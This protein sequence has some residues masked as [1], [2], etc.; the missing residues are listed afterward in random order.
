MNPF[1]NTVNVVLKGSNESVFSFRPAMGP[2]R[3]Q[4]FLKIIQGFASEN[5]PT[6][7]SQ[8]VNNDDEGILKLSQMQSEEEED[9]SV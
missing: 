7:Y 9:L 4:T 6:E 3:L 8:V 5:Q 2:A 1:P